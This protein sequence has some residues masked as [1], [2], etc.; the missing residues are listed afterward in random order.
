M[1]LGSGPEAS[2][3]STEREREVSVEVRGVKRDHSVLN[4]GFQSVVP[5]PAAST[6]LENLLEMKILHLYSRSA[7]S[8]TLG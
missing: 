3:G 2:T 1:I 5:K 7:E 6:S 8:E 4:S